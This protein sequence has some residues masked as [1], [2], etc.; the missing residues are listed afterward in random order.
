MVEREPYNSCPVKVRNASNWKHVKIQ[1]LFSL[2]SRACC[3]SLTTGMER[4]EMGK[5]RKIAELWG[6][7][8]TNK[9]QNRITKQSLILKLINIFSV[10]GVAMSLISDTQDYICNYKNEK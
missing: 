4:K 7:K 1:K 2:I 10:V 3:Q 9:P 6:E 5:C 8:Q